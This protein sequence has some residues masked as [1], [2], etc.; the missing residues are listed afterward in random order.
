MDLN[1]LVKSSLEKK[2]IQLI[3]IYALSSFFIGKTQLESV[4]W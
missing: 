2:K 4:I 1:P 3:F